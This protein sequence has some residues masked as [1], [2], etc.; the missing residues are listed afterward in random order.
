MILQC[1]QG[2]A[3]HTAAVRQVHGNERAELVLLVCLFLQKKC[4]ALLQE[5]RHFS[6]TYPAYSYF[7]G[8]VSPD[9][10]SDVRHGFCA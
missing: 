8:L 2:K 6:K 9:S 4:T 10:D 1:K 5:V 3:R 7:R